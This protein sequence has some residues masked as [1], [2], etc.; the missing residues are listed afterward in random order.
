MILNSHHTSGPIRRVAVNPIEPCDLDLPVALAVGDTYADGSTEVKLFMLRTDV[1]GD[2][3]WHYVRTIGCYESH[4]TAEAKAQQVC[5]AYDVPVLDIRA[6]RQAASDTPLARLAHDAW[7]R[8]ASRTGS[9]VMHCALCRLPP[10]VL[11]PNRTDAQ[12]SPCW[13]LACQRHAE[14]WP[15]WSNPMARTLPF[16]PLPP[17]VLAT[18]DK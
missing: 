8:R 9:A 5:A 12:L 1:N 11:V 7:A 10:V 15:R 3:D 16:L 2:D 6:D 17:S 13:L 4:G 14:E 18:K